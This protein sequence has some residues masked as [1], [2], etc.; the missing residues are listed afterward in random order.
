[1][2]GANLTGVQ[3]TCEVNDRPL[4]PTCDDTCIFGVEPSSGRSTGF[5]TA[6]LAASGVP[7]VQ[8]Q[9]MKLSQVDLEGARLAGGDFSRYDFSGSDFSGA[10]LAGTLLNGTNLD[11][12]E[13]HGL[14]RLR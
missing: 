3:A 11:G 6:I 1:M 10:N 4:V 12:V 5:S 7:S 2:T 8:F 13:L 9:G 14:T